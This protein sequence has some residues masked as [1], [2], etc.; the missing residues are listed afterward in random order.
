MRAEKSKSR[1]GARRPPARR[2]AGRPRTPA[3]TVETT[4]TGGIRTVSRARGHEV[5]ADG[6]AWRNGTDDGPAPGELMLAAVGAC[7]VNHLARSLE[8]ELVP[9]RGVGAKVTGTFKRV[10]DLDVFDAF[11]FDVTVRAPEASRGLVREALE[12]ARAECTLL[13][14]VDVEKEFALELVPDDGGGDGHA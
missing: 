4:W 6:P 13:L 1:G 11:R 7:L 5:V 10:G 9:F 14:V 3:F 8:R 2:A 12:V